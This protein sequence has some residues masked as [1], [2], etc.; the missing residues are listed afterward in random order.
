MKRVNQNKNFMKWIAFS[1]PYIASLLSDLLIYSLEHIFNID[2]S[3][4]HEQTI[5]I[6]INSLGIL[7]GI[8]IISNYTHTDNCENYSPSRK[9]FYKLK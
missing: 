9:G 8:G 6:I 1:F 2:I 5:F 7:F 3:P 4:A